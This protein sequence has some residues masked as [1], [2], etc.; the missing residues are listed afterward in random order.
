LIC[1]PIIVAGVSQDEWNRLRTAAALRA[2]IILNGTSGTYEGHGFRV[3]WSYDASS[4]A[5]TVT[6]QD[7]P[8]ACPLFEGLLRHAVAT[9]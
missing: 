3:D 2:Q 8:I 5:I 1:P 7:I 6:P 9:I 4:G